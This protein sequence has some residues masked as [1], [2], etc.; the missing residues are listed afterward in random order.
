[1]D[2]RYQTPEIVTH[3]TSPNAIL[4]SWEV[5]E[6]ITAK[7]QADLGIIP[8]E[9]F[10]AIVSSVG[11]VTPRRVAELEKTTRHD[12]AAF[13]QAIR[14]Q[15]PPELG[16][17]VHYGLTS[18][19]V[20]DTAQAGRLE[21]ARDAILD[22]VRLLSH[23]LQARSADSPRQRIGRTHGQHAEVV[24]GRT[25]FLRAL[26]DLDESS[27]SLRRVLIYGKISGPVGGHSKAIT[28]DVENLVLRHLHLPTD[29]YATQIT[30]RMAYQRFAYLL[31]EIMTILESL[32]LDL[33]LLAQ[34]EIAEVREGF[35]PGQV[36]SS[37]M[38]HKKNPIR[39]EQ[40][41]GMARLARGYLLPIMETTGGLWLERD[42]SNSAVERV[43][44]W[45]LVQ[46]VHY[47]VR[48]SV[49]LIR[50]LDIRRDHAEAVAQAHQSSASE[51][52]DAVAQG[53]DANDAYRRIQQS[54]HEETK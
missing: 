8:A 6:R 33:R 24:A 54:H 9:V 23:A 42:I 26:R 49:S 25:L 27:R 41:S 37:A 50:E 11:R 12:V 1:M 47:S 13:V 53:E 21:Y 48:A 10:P 36:G 15:M 35:A 34:T 7:V 3:C 29:P 44:L 52:I 18:S 32:A 17:F 51:L 40:L 20:V 2:T 16:S 30:S 38:P 22:E 14:E 4:Y 5:V 39:L 46:L 31:V 43:A 28:P 45:D 19:D